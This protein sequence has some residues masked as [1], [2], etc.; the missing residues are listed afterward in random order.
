METPQILPSKPTPS[1]VAPYSK[2]QV[3]THSRTCTGNRPLPR[4]PRRERAE[5][6]HARTVGVTTVLG[7]TGRWLRPSSTRSLMMRSE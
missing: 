3:S 2:T 7:R 4:M 1:Y 6:G 5:L